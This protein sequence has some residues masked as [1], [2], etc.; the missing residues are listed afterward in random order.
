MSDVLQSIQDGLALLL[1]VLSF[2]TIIVL[3]LV[4]ILCRDRFDR[5]RITASVESRGW[6]VLGVTPA[7]RFWDSFRHRGVRR[8]RVVYRTNLYEVVTGECVTSWFRGTEWVS[9]VPLGPVNPPG[10]LF[11][12]NKESAPWGAGRQSLAQRIRA[13]LP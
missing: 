3:P 10:R 5:W 7:P 4:L 6:G 11:R 1:A 9:A 2:G 8:Y 12:S 13:R